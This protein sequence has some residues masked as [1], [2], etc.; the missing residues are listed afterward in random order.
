MIAGYTLKRLSQ[1]SKKFPNTIAIKESSKDYTY[2]DFFNMVLDISNKILSRKKGSIIAIIGEKNILSYV[3]IFGVLMSGG[4]YIPISSSLPTKRIGRIITKGKANIII[5]N[6]NKLNFYKKIFPKK[7]F[8]TERNLSTNKKDCKIKVKK[9][10]NLAY[11]IFTS[12]STGEPKGVCI[13]RNSLDHYVK[14]L[15]LNF[16]IKKGHNCSQFPEISF[17]LSVADI[18]GTLCSGG[19]LIPAITVYDKLFPGRFIKN[20]KINFLVCVPS[21]IDVIKSSSDL[22]AKNLKSLKSIFFCGEALLR[23]HVENIFKAKKKIRI[24]NAYGPTEATVSCT[25]K[26][27]RY[28]DLNNKKFHSI[29]IGA[30]IPGMKI[31]LL[32]Q[33][34]FSKKKGEIII[35]GNQLAQ[36]YLDKKDNKDKFFFSKK[37]SVYFKTGDFVEV[38]KEEMY[39]KN[40]IDTQIKIKGHRIELDEITTN[41]NKYGIKNVHTIILKDKIISFY[42]DKK[43]FK[44]KLILNFLKKYIPD[45]MIPD[46]IF[47][48]NKFPLS[49]NGKLDVNN[50][51]KLAKDKII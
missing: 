17:D 34:K 14:W 10:N 40:R 12:G 11:I 8:F 26:E 39:F 42:S 31:K 4:T 20:K 38:N 7:F 1:I 16:N 41:L 44:N 29:S 50:L 36:G 15:N 22:T 48:L 51:T 27:V 47:K 30:P 13:S 24:I 32:D 37:K 25:Y 46:Y 43:K 6:S 45:Y 33:G 2:K 35:Y 3:S 21:L 23:S 28:E 18:Y 19:T 49:Y 5:C 9:I